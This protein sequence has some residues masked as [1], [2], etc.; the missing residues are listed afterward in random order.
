M[1]KF[2]MITAT[3]L[4]FGV[5]LS[6]MEKSHTSIT[7]ISS[8]QEAFEQFPVKNSLL[9][10]GPGKSIVNLRKIGEPREQT[11]TRESQLPKGP[12]KQFTTLEIIQTSIGSWIVKKPKAKL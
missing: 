9:P 3:A 6:A 1:K 4:S 7:L 8:S 11:P 5:T 10:K 12:E 2:L